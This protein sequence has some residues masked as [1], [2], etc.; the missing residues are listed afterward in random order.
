MTTSKSASAVS[1]SAAHVAREYAKY[2]LS[3]AHAA[4]GDNLTNGLTVIRNYLRG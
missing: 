1:A 2:Q 3:F 4:Q